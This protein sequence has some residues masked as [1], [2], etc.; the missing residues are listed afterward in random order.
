MSSQNESILRHTKAASLGSIISGKRINLGMIIGQD[1]AIRA[2]QRQTSLPFPVLITNLGRRAQV[3]FDAKKDVE[4]T[5]TSC[6]DIRWIETE[7]LKDEAEKK[8]VV[9]VDT[10]P[11]VYTDTLP[12]EAF[13]PTLI[14]KPLGISSVAPSMTPSSFSAPFPP[15]SCTAAAIS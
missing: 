1:M 10:S 9:L 13:L 8:K 15:R 11:I 14:S 2:K 4:V 12:A 6:T 5:P 7:Y 3:P